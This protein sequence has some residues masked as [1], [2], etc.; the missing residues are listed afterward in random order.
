MEHHVFAVWD[1]MSL[2][3]SLQ[4]TL[5]CTDV[6]WMPVGS[7]GTRYLINEVFLG[8]E[9]DVDAA[10]NRV[11][12]FELYQLAMRQAGCVVNGIGKL[13]TEL[14]GGRNIGEAMIIADIPQAARRFLQ[15]TFDVIASGKDYLQA[16][17]FIFGRQGL[18]PGM[19]ISMLKE[20]SRQFPGKVEIV[21][22]YLKR[23]IEVD[24][25]NHSH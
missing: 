24:G 22:Y 12:H 19:F 10:G 6:P 17:V 4:Q 3:Q 15:H 7:A 25:E 18:I 20:I 8:E 5:T 14:N 9:S 23:R 13:F 11:S 2:R 16:A 21:L 1:F